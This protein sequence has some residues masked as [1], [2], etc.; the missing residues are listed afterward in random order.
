MT[1]TPTILLDLLADRQLNPSAIRLDFAEACPNL[2]QAVDADALIRL[3]QQ[4]PCLIDAEGYA[5]LPAELQAQLRNAG[6]DTVAAHSVQTTN[7]SDSVLPAS[8]NWLDGR[9]YLAAPGG[10]NRQSPSR[11]LALQLMQLVADDADT[12]EIENVFRQDPVLAYH[13]LRLVNSLG[14]GSGRHVSSFAQAILILGRQQLKRWLNLMLFAASRDDRRAPMLMARVAVRARTMEQL[15]KAAGLDRWQ[16]EQ[17]FMCGM[18]SLLGILFGMPLADLLKPLRLAPGLADA[19]LLRNT[20]I[21][22]LL[23]CVE[24]AEY[25][26]RDALDAQ[27]AAF[28]LVAEQWNRVTLE[29]HLWMLGALHGQQEVS[30]A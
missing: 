2:E 29:A 21:G 22:R 6:V 20:G 7:D 28:G 10:Q 16:Q 12:H 11:T 17:A 19:L 18:F 14:V 5:G 30:H 24:D 9:W 26:R 13:L 23:Q 8:A 4:I 25:R 27:L 15:A 1:S 3:A